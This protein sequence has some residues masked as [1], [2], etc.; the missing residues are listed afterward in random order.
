MDLLTPKLGVNSIIIVDN[1]ISHASKLKDFCEKMHKESGLNVKIL[2]QDN[3][4]MLIEK[5]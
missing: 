3:G 1:I 2:E 4:L 5:K